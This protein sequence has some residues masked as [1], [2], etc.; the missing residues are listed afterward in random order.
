MVLLINIKGSYAPNI[1]LKKIKVCE[2]IRARTNQL[3]FIKKK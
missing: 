1:I 2:G 3:N